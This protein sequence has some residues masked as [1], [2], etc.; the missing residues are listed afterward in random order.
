MISKYVDV[1]AI[2]VLLGGA[3]LYSGARH[4]SLI[5]VVPNKRIALSETI[6]RAM[7][8]S[9]SVRAQRASRAFSLPA[10]HLT[11]TSD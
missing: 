8:C 1:I 4:L 11:I 7:R 3:A 6:Q 2:G 9:H 5:E 10:P